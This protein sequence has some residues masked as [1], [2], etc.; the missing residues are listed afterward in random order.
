MDFAAATTEAAAILMSRC[1]GQREKYC[2]KGNTDLGNP[3]SLH[4]YLLALQMVGN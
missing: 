4:S 2:C 3:F 1:I